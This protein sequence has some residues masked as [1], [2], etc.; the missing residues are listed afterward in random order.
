[1]I[2]LKQILIFNC[3]VFF[4]NIFIINKN[5]IMINFR[6]IDYMNIKFINYTY[7]NI[8]NY[9]NAK[10]YISY[11]IINA[12]EKKNNSKKKIRLYFSDFSPSKSGPDQIKRLINIFKQY[13]EII[14]EPNNP[15][16]LIYST[17]GCEFMKKKYFN[18]IKIAYYTENQLPD[19]NI[20]YYAY[21][22][23][24]ITYLDR[25][26]GVPAIVRVLNYFK[27]HLNLK[28]RLYALNHP[29]KKFCGA[30][31]SNCQNWAK[32]RLNFINELNKYKKI[33]MGGKCNKNAKK[34]ENKILF[35]SEYKF[36]IA[37]ENSEADGYVSEKIID[38]FESGTIPIYYGNYMVEEF[39]NPKSFILIRGEK[40]MKEKIELIKK[41]DNDNNLYKKMLKENIFTDIKFKE[42]MLFQKK[43]FFF[44]IFQ[45]DHKKVRRIDN[46][47]WKF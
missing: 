40:D 1:M 29:R 36:S 46:Y 30:V 6:N 28:R 16:Y 10:Y 13:F 41:I 12:I 20:A 26:I 18:S 27:F 34:I 9:L 15:D 47:H 31:I 33:D 11:N 24:H 19:F 22:E 43:N 17:F 25:Y 14:L 21:G 35:L 37:M 4:F 5:K 2:I 3:I 32:F 8:S 44:H 45:Q 39:I 23:S 7:T 42:K 38:S